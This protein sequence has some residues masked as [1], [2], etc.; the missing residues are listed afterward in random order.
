M[1]GAR[2]I[3]LANAMAFRGKPIPTMSRDELLEVIGV[4][5]ERLGHFEAPQ[6]SALIAAGQAQLFVRGLGQ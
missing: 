1:T 2:S 4:L 5:A 3:E 6:M